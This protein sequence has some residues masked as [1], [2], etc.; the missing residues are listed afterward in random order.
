MTSVQNPA[1][2]LSLGVLRH[3]GACLRDTSRQGVHLNNESR[4]DNSD[5]F[6]VLSAVSVQGEAGTTPAEQFDAC[7]S[8][9][10]DIWTGHGFYFARRDT[11]RIH[12]FHPLALIRRRDWNAKKVG[13]Q[14]AA[15]HASRLTKT[16]AAFYRNLNGRTSASFQ[17]HSVLIEPIKQ[18]QRAYEREAC[19][20]LES[21]SLHFLILI[22]SRLM[23]LRSATIARSLCSPAA[24]RTY[25]SAPPQP[26][27]MSGQ[28][29]SDD[30]IVVARSFY[31]GAH[32]QSCRFNENPSRNDSYMLPGGV[33]RVRVSS[34]HDRNNGMGV[35]QNAAQGLQGK[36]RV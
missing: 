36:N 23:P 17:E 35:V 18:D 27:A 26:F 30:F 16:F 2:D 28:L 24:P 7:N 12:I 9:D 33:C 14:Y 1:H 19:T 29:A 5:A 10:V 15:Q 11:Q 32:F 20:E 22:R 34:S 25:S 4:D 13:N 8:V 21:K 3:S 31:S 6:P